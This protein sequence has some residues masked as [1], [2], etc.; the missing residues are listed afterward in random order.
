MVGKSSKYFIFLILLGGI[1][2]TIVGDVIGTNFKFLYFFKS[3]YTIGTAKPIFLDFKVL[4][5]TLGIN[6]NVNII[7]IVGIIL[8]IMLYKKH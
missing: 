7:T 5:L 8:A 1:G 3:A 2:G 6:F 4:N